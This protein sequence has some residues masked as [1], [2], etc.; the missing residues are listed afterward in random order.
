MRACT[1]MT[2]FT[3]LGFMPFCFNH[4]HNHQVH[5]LLV[6]H[7]ASMTSFQALR[8][9]AIPL[10]SFHDF[11]ALIS[12]SIALRHILFSLP[13][14]LYPWGFQSNAIFSIGPA[15]LGNVCPIHFHFLLFWF[16]IDF[17]R[18]Y[19]F[20]YISEMQ[21]YTVYLFLENCSTCFGWY[22][23]PSSG[24]HITVFT[25]SGTC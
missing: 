7:K 21:L 5:L 22:L 24:A 16:P 15:S 13:L 3:T 10:T 20:W 18:M 1:P 2:C 19:S 6:E 14:L 8:S 12:S 11:L 25:V 17:C 23:H 9:P 4:H